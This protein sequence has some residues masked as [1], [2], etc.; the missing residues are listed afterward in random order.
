MVKILKPQR[1]Q[2][3][4]GVV[5]QNYNFVNNQ[6]CQSFYF[7]Y[8][9]GL[10]GIIWWHMSSKDSSYHRPWPPLRPKLEVKCFLSCR[11][12]STHWCSTRPKSYLMPRNLRGWA[13]RAA[14]RAEGRW[15]RAEIFLAKHRN[16]RNTTHFEYRRSL[17]S[18]FLFAHFWMLLSWF[19]REP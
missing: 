8:L 12:S 1:A 16:W 5:D 2:L 13:A 18:S 17:Q 9:N 4:F 14:A 15:L 10:I 3:Y 19:G 6:L 11:L 7:V